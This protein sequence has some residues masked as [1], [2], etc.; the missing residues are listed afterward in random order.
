MP[1]ILSI[2]YYHHSRWICISNGKDKIK[3]KWGRIGRDFYF[4]QDGISFNLYS[5]SENDFELQRNIFLLWN[6]E[7]PV[8]RISCHTVLQK[9]VLFKILQ[10]KQSELLQ[11]K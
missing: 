7:F 3:R 9:Q 5:G 4:S 8:I 1:F 2:C 6:T 10:P 11:S